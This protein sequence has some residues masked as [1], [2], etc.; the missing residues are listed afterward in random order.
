[1]QAQASFPLYAQV[2]PKQ[3]VSY[4]RSR[5]RNCRSL[6]DILENDALASVL[7]DDFDTFR[8]NDDPNSALTS[9]M[10]SFV[11]ANEGASNSDFK[12]GM[13]PNSS[14][15]KAWK[16]TDDLQD[17]YVEIQSALLDLSDLSFVSYSHKTPERN[18]SIDSS[19]DGK[20]STYR[21]SGCFS[22]AAP[23][24]ISSSSVYM[25]MD[26]D[27]VRLLKSQSSLTSQTL[28][29]STV[30]NDSTPTHEWARDDSLALERKTRAPPSQF[31]SLD[32]RHL[33]RAISKELPN[34][35]TAS[36]S[37]NISP[38]TLLYDEENLYVEVLENSNGKSP[39]AVKQSSIETR[40]VRALSSDESYISNSTHDGSKQTASQT[41]T[42]TLKKRF[43][44]ILK[45]KS[46]NVGKVENCPKIERACIRTTPLPPVPTVSNSAAVFEDDYSCIS[47]H[48]VPHICTL[49]I[50][51]GNDNVTM[52]GGTRCS[53]LQTRTPSPIALSTCE[54]PDVIFRR[55]RTPTELFRRSLSP[56]PS[57]NK[58]RFST[59]SIQ[60]EEAL[61]GSVG[62]FKTIEPNL[63]IRRSPSPAPLSPL[64]TE[65]PNIDPSFFSSPQKIS[66]PV[67]KVR[68]TVSASTLPRTPKVEYHAATLGRYRPQ[69]IDN[70]TK[71][72]KLE[73]LDVLLQ[74]FDTSL[75]ATSSET[76]TTSNDQD[77]ESS[78]SS[79]AI[80]SLEE[81]PEKQIFVS[82][83]IEKSS[84]NF[85]DPLEFY[86]SNNIP[87]SLSN[88]L[89]PAEQTAAPLY[90]RVQ[91]RSKFVDP[92]VCK[93]E[94][95]FSE[96]DD[97]A[98][99]T[100][101]DLYN[102]PKRKFHSRLFSCCKQCDL[103]L[104]Q[105]ASHFINLILFSN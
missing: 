24:E 84:P 29:T 101:D 41:H 76:D 98:E 72:E 105:C 49:A 26:V 47:D 71:E 34:T 87:L 62:A 66:K 78:F 57:P 27:P 55:S 67:E 40:G 103:L 56:L 6:D 53:P 21:D 16:S 91:K 32:R 73:E 33:R 75:D 13:S 90:S 102:M 80:E 15:K 7:T 95:S 81:S 64:V 60:F 68:K 25:S 45:S 86:Q 11:C 19:V 51:S 30:E 74:D 18:I 10:D 14:F 17:T 43:G 70:R 3:S 23:S 97:Y 94:N 35:P 48:Q 92:K 61:A 83:I 58:N 42:S 2:R 63:S 46:P 59:G 88:G 104:V 89:T 96:T 82:D 4:D 9:Q 12:R 38:N 85:R 1:M 39:V 37:S 99:I 31:S 69:K 20:T 5:R 93:S 28:S 8:D 79:I 36:F 44:G 77:I 22:D 54:S 100:E 52:L 50:P 65:F